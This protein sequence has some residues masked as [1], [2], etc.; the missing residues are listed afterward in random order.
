MVN[1]PGILALFGGIHNR[2]II[3]E[4]ILIYLMN[5]KKTQ[6]LFLKN[7]VMQISSRQQSIAACLRLALILVFVSHIV[8]F[9]IAFVFLANTISPSL[10][11][12]CYCLPKSVLLWMILFKILLLVYFLS[13]IW[14]NFKSSNHSFSTITFLLFAVSLAT[15]LDFLVQKTKFYIFISRVFGGTGSPLF[16][17]ASIRLYA[18]LYYNLSV[19][20]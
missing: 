9:C 15:G 10:I 7:R 11:Y 19:I 18:F 17:V 3:R 6:G 20:F 12:N 5:T 16:L 13:S 2:F 14:L 1:I 4:N 8:D